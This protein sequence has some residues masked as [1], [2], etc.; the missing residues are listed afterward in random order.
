MD[1]IINGLSETFT[2]FCATQPPPLLTRI[3]KKQGK[4]PTNEMEKKLKHYHT[5]R[6]AIYL[7]QHDDNWRLRPILNKLPPNTPNPL[8]MSHLM[9]D[10]I[11][12]FATIGK[13]AKKEAKLIVNK[14]T[15]SNI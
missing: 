11:K 5:I 3:T 9:N 13:N 7:T 1:I 6:K 4:K 12:E 14:Q 2:K 10:W 15:M 8:S